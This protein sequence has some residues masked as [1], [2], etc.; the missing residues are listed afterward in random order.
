IPL[1]VRIV[2]EGEPVRILGAWVGKDIHPTTAW[3]KV[4]SMIKKNLQRW[5]R[6]KPTLYGKRLIL[7]MAIGSRT[8]YLTRVQSMPKTVENELISIMRKF[9]WNKS[10]SPRIGLDELYKKKKEGG[11]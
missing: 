1:A 6:R 3:P 8:Q 2:A 5:G 9:M 10:R 4:V 11:L 7:G